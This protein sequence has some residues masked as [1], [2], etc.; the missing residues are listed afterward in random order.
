LSTTYSP[1]PGD[2]FADV[3]RRVYGSEQHAGELAAANPGAA[4]PLTPGTPLF[5][6]DL[7]DAPTD[8]PADAPSNTA[9]E[10]SVLIDG[11]RFRFW[12]DMQLVRSLDAMDTLEFA[13]P[14]DPNAPGFREVFRPF[15]YKPLDVTVG[16]VPLFTG[17]LI[18]VTPALSAQSKT[19]A[20]S[21][22]SRAGVLNDCTPPASAF[23]IE[24]DGLALPEIAARLCAP[25]GVGVSAPGGAGPT[26]ERVAV[27]PGETVQSFLADLAR[28]RAHVLSS[29][30][31]GELL[32]QQSVGPGAPVAVLT[33]GDSPLL[34]VTPTFSPQQYYSH[35][36]GLESVNV[37]TEGSQ[38]TVRNPHLAGVLRPMTFNPAD[39]E[40]GDIT[41]A[42][43][44]KAGRMFGNAASYSVAVSTWRDP[45]GE[46]WVPNT[47]IILTAPGAMVYN[48]YEFVIRQV[49]FARN[50]ASSTAT[51][52]LVL[53]GSF[54]GQTP[55]SLPWD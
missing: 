24:F 33:Q 31:T 18:G 50:A 36:T 29:T 21:G 34:S 53:P 20:V 41:T 22:Y 10:A 54:S 4:D 27:D 55:E 7:P 45:Q 26:F 28:Q 39:V 32:I 15:S 43:A 52:D 3:S 8:K 49:R 38:Y 25:F 51:L 48:A 17:T 19:A 1:V 14:F 16:G 2:T 13:A 37:G 30:P 44:A 9:D 23:P 46:L 40:G 35:V 5:V 11:Q 6:P 42:V 47:T 12:S